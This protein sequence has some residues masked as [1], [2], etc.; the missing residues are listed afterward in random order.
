LQVVERIGHRT[1]IALVTR[2]RGQLDHARGAPGEAIPA[3]RR[4]LRIWREIGSPIEVARGLA[5]LECAAAAV[6]D[7]PA[8]A[9]HRREWRAILDQLDLDE[10]C[11]RLPRYLR[12]PS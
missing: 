4:S 8:A 3:Y 11:L 2:T 9:E 10:P 5:R 7:E 1:G 12:P 6:G